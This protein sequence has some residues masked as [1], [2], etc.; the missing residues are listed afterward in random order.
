VRP[1]KRRGDSSFTL[2]EVMLAVAVFAFAAVGFTVALNEV[3]G[4]NVELLR[5]GMRRQAVES[6]AARILAVTN[7]LQ[8]TRREFRAVEDDGVF[9]LKAAVNPI[10]PPIE[11][12]GTNNSAA[13]RRLGGW[14]EVQIQATTKK[15][16]PLESISLLMWPQR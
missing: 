16:A 12:P 9:F 3:I 13:P 15:G 10:D 7:N 2:I 14:W 4:I 1:A 8:P 11:L 5:T 6:C